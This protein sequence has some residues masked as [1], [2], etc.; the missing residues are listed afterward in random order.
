MK[1]RRKQQQGSRP[2]HWR[3]ED[4]QILSKQILERADT[5]IPRAQFLKEVSSLMLAFS[6][7]AVIGMALSD[8]ERCYRCELRRETPGSFRYEEMSPASDRD[9]ATRW[10]PT[11]NDA[12]QQLCSDISNRNFDSALPWF[13][14]NGSF[15]SGDITSHPQP[16]LFVARPEQ[17]LGIVIHADTRSLLLIAVGAGAEQLGLIEMASAEVDFFNRRLITSLESV[18]ETL[19]IALSQRRLQEALR[20]RVKELTCLYGIA[21]QAA[22]PGISLDEVL[23]ETVKL[24][25]PGWLYPEACCARIVLD[26]QTFATRGYRRPLQRMQ[27]DLVVDSR[28]RGIVEVGYTWEK[29][30]LDEGPFL[31]E[32]RN[33]I[34]A[35][36]QEISIIIEQKQTEQEKKQLQEQLHRADR[37]ATI[38][39]L[40][41]GLAHELNEPLANILGY[42]QLVAKEAAL[43]EQTRADIDKIV[44][45]SLHA[46]EVITKLLLF[47]RETTPARTDVD[48]NALVQAGLYFLHHRCTKAG[49]ALS[50]D[51]C[52]S[53]PEI[54]GERSQLIQVLTNLVVNAVQAMPQGGELTIRTGLQNNHVLLTVEDTGTGMSEDILA[55]IFDPFFTTK[56][57]DEGT[58][59]GLSVVHGI[60]ISHSGTIEVDSQLGRGTKFIVRLPLNAAATDMESSNG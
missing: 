55:M 42:A 9:R 1:N 35:I 40:G 56:D 5:G 36:A 39:Q 43:S 30:P 34:N 24:I 27:A 21:R 28:Q 7:C 53:L 23:R 18:S 54:T 46:R 52:Q 25:P 29:P 58:G 47:A 22:R 45:A 37:L 50:L 15:Y 13:T 57:V 17:D 38:G 4:T 60:V 2:V 19:G 31:S 41:A 12:L 51:L 26:K 8:R 10:S 16:G 49:I 48:L 44:K 20:E 59:L 11:G 6:G 14:E 32:E 33:L 3:R